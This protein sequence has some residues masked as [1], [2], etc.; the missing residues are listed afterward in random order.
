M[1]AIGSFAHLTGLSVKALRHYHAI[2]LLVPDAVDDDTRHRRYSIGQAGTAVLIRALRDAGLPLTDVARAMADGTAN[3]V[4]A[5]HR[6]RVAAR[7]AAEDH[8]AERAGTVLDGLDDLVQVDVV[9]CGRQPFVA[10]AL[11]PTGAAGS[12][13]DE[14]AHALATL[15]ER[16]TAAG[17]GSAGP[18]W[19]TA[20]ETSD[21]GVELV[22][23]WPLT[24]LP[25]EGW[26]HPGDELG[27]LPARRE[28]RC[29]W[30]AAAG[31][32][33]DR[34]LLVVSRLADEL[35]ARGADPESADIRQ[36]VD[37]A[38]GRAEIAVTLRDRDGDP[39]PSG[40]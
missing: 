25:P 10:R 23:A 16:I 19:M 15:P 30:D 33:D 22:C 9:E 34:A 29:S 1:L 5:A 21:E 11:H 7:R 4:L 27:M 13:P 14:E 8:A 6:S 39:P 31:D 28:L 18:W 24:R 12:L 38:V 35:A 20:R 37:V 3:A 2:G 36:R 26:A 17:L 32:D 40:G